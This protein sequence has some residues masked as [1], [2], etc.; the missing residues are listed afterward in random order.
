MVD[1]NFMWWTGHERKIE[2][3]KKRI[4]LLLCYAIID[5]T[6]F[7]IIQDSSK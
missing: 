4:L 5:F 2:R 3:M 6:A 7:F 1:D